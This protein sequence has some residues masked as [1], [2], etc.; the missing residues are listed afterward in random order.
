MPCSPAPLRRSTAEGSSQ[1]CPRARRACVCPTG[2][3]EKRYLGRQF[4]EP[5]VPHRTVQEHHAL[6]AKATPSPERLPHVPR[7]GRTSARDPKRRALSGANAPHNPRT[8]QPASGGSTGSR[9]NSPNPLQ[10]PLVHLHP[11]G[12]AGRGRGEEFL[13]QDNCSSQSG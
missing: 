6:G 11:P 8:A 7:W 2:R 4:Q 9:S 13:P 3:A 1:D 10:G 12:G 5:R